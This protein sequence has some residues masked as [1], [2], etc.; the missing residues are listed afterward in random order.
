VAKLI[1][2]I[3]REIAQS[4]DHA[5]LRARIK[6]L[7]DKWEP[8]LGVHVVEWRL[9]DLKRYWASV[10]EDQ[11][12]ISFSTKLADVPQAFLEVTVVHELV[13]LLTDGHD[14]KFYA[15]MDRHV[16]GWRK[17]HERFAERLTRH[18]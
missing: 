12:K 7:V 3:R 16:P 9:Q 13:H 2:L 10:N 6:H 8:I 4:S 1:S 15:L 5:R 11:A 18:S 17:V 14:K